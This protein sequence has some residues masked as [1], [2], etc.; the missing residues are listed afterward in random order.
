MCVNI[1][2]G[3]SNSWWFAQIS[4][5]MSID[6][7]SGKGYTPLPQS[8]SNT[9]TEDEEDCLETQQN[10]APKRHAESAPAVSWNLE[11]LFPFQQYGMCN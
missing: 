5:G 6:H 7:H 9:D 1:L 4:I 11:E 10:E 3:F 2:L 8:I